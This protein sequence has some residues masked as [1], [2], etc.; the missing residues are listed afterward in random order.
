MLVPQL[1]KGACSVNPTPF[2]RWKLVAFVFLNACDLLLT[3]VLISRSRGTVYESNPLADQWL[4]HNGWI[5]LALFKLAS[6]LV[7]AGLAAWVYRLRPQMAHDL[8]AIA[9]G[10]VVVAVFSGTTIAMSLD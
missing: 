7:V 4:R 1:R 6:V 8:V 9:C 3:Y 5:G 2:P 10:C